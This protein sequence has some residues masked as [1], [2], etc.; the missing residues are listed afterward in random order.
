MILD[1]S[2]A[3][4]STTSE[5]EVPEEFQN[6]VKNW[7]ANY[8]RQAK[9]AFIPYPKGA[10]SH[11]GCFTIFLERKGDDPARKLY[12]EGVQGATAYEAVPLQEWDILAQEYVPLNIHEYGPG[13]IVQIL[14]KGDTWS[15]TGEYKDMREAAAASIK[16]M[17]RARKAERDAVR[18]S[19]KETGWLH[20]RTALGIPFVG[21][22]GN[23]VD[24]AGN[25]KPRVDEKVFLFEDTSAP[26][27]P[28]ESPSTPT[29]EP[30]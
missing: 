5:F 17:E 3:P 25:E 21:A 26:A 19:G 18:E 4:I 2:G 9:M 14:Q 28:G 20:R 7:A 15:G 29:V 13:G 12:Q 10:S 1:S 11:P 6:A 24:H 27:S 23:K 22:S 16:R 30:K 8:G